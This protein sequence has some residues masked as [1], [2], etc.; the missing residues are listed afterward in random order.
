MCGRFNQEEPGLSR[1]MIKNPIREFPRYNI[2]AGMPA[3]L[4]TQ[5]GWEMGVFGLRPKWDPKKLFINARAEGKGNEGNARQGW[6]VGIH[7]MPSFRNGFRSNRAI[8][9]VTG[10]IEGPEKERL[11]K[12]FLF[13][14]KDKI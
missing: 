5:K 8:L 10:F 14:R 9:P 4:L 6:E 1:R 2:S 3:A 12:P 7:S 13:R 11:S